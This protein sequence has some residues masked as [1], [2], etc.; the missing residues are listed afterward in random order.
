VRP[1]GRLSTCTFYATFNAYLPP[2]Y[3]LGLYG[4]GHRPTT[5][6]IITS[7]S[8]TNRQIH[9]CLDSV[10]LIA[11]NPW[12]K[13]TMSEAVPNNQSSDLLS[14]RI[15]NESSSNNDEVEPGSSL[16]DYSSPTRK[17]RIVR[18]RRNSMGVEI[19]RSYT[20][21]APEVTKNGD[22]IKSSQIERIP[23]SP[24][25]PS[26][27]Q[28]R[29]SSLGASMGS[30]Y[31]YNNDINLD[32]KI[33]TLISPSKKKIVRVR[34]NSLGVEIERTYA[35]GTTNDDFS[36]SAG[37]NCS[38]NVQ[39]PSSPS[40][41]RFVRIHRNSSGVE[42]GRSYV[43]APKAKQDITVMNSTSSIGSKTNDTIPSVQLSPTAALGQSKS[44]MFSPGKISSPSKVASQRMKSISRNVHMKAMEQSSSDINTLDLLLPPIDAG[45]GN[46]SNV[47]EALLQKKSIR[48]TTT[49]NKHD[50]VPP[51]SPA[52]A[53]KVKSLKANLSTKTAE[54]GSPGNHFITSPSLRSRSMRMYP[55]TDNAS[56]TDDHQAQSLRLLRVLLGE[57]NAVMS[58]ENV[59]KALEK[60][61]ELLRFQLQQKKKIKQ[62]DEMIQQE[63]KQQ[64]EMMEEHKRQIVKLNED[65]QKQKLL[66][67]TSLEIKDVE[68]GILTKESEQ[69]TV[70]VQQLA[71][72]L[73]K[74]RAAAKES[75]SHDSA[76]SVVSSEGQLSDN[77]EDSNSL[78]D[79]LN[80]IEQP[81]ELDD[82]DISEATPLVGHTSFSS[83]PSPNKSR[84]SSSNGEG[85]ES[86]PQMKTSQLKKKLDQT[87]RQLLIAKKSILQLE[88]KQQEM[89]LDFEETLHESKA[90]VTQLKAVLTACNERRRVAEQMLRDLGK[91]DEA[92]LIKISRKPPNELM[93]DISERGIA[94]KVGA[95]TMSE[96]ENSSSAR[97]E[98]VILEKEVENLRAQLNDAKSRSFKLEVDN[99]MS[100]K[101]VQATKEEKAKLES[102]LTSLQMKLKDCE[103]QLAAAKTKNAEKLKATATSLRE[104]E[105]VTTEC[106]V[107]N[108]MN[109]V[110]MESQIKHLQLELDES[111][112]MYAKLQT[113]LSLKV[114][115]SVRA[116]AASEERSAKLEA[117]M[118]QAVNNKEKV[119]R[120]MEQ[121]QLELDEARLLLHQSESMIKKYASRLQEANATVKECEETIAK[122]NEQIEFKNNE[123]ANGSV[124]PSGEVTADSV[125]EIHAML[126]ETQVQVKE[127]E[128]K[129]EQVQLA[130]QESETMA[131]KYLL[132]L[133]EANA[134][135]EQSEKLMRQYDRMQPNLLLHG[136]SSID[137]SEIASG[138]SESEGTDDLSMKSTQDLLAYASKRLNG[139][140]PN[141]QICDDTSNVVDDDASNSQSNVFQ[142]KG[143][144]QNKARGT[145]HFKSSAGERQECS[146]V[147]SVT[148]TN[149]GEI[150]H[151]GNSL[152]HKW[153]KSRLQNASISKIAALETELAERQIQLNE[154]L[155]KIADLTRSKDAA[156][157]QS[158]A[159][160][161]RNGD[162]S[163]DSE[164]AVALAE[165]TELKERVAIAEDKYNEATKKLIFL[166]ETVLT[167]VDTKMSILK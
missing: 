115:E 27:L 135:L 104:I 15:N 62:R 141:A 46:N 10:T 102:Q 122:L 129:L 75:R 3:S 159:A 45:S 84:K 5:S 81:K 125:A 7:K 65:V 38:D 138:D 127:Y 90:K 86:S 58:K 17:T 117:E 97:K 118:L 93:S 48:S 137:N 2:V 53:R 130:L 79:L 71:W 126:I 91:F 67:K 99:E 89:E 33:S 69:K 42:I 154:A 134:T 50:S 152:L 66:M 124:S 21:A 57:D 95:L 153:E 34:R 131:E 9:Y 82:D 133:E 88:K 70:K 161:V 144:E 64:E 98:H 32:S 109:K 56:N 128:T 16:I 22:D 103:V 72:R 8:A 14:P 140:P 11:S 41:T 36:N 77:K 146:D 156:T 59:D 44:S 28:H 111:R 132:M 52:T 63:K 80:I 25:K 23:L 143:T 101:E 149:V 30:A 106:S 120:D 150:D 31:D 145:F 100:V 12:I 4:I 155:H 74:E 68:I 116:M 108:E 20:D 107:A 83:F 151:T 136:G 43:D 119:E 78:L 166:K 94:M 148:S 158:G 60:H 54:G 157:V 110:K 163:P 139:I 35:D 105:K 13:K 123:H 40:K 87:E 18:V 147:S 96:S 24:L 167:V 47:D 160:N 39:L 26:L 51:I 165:V 113:E 162:M 92:T 1:F 85:D 29:R 61:A 164:L 73:A 121:H 142:K 37:S 76:I 55:G 19:G 112:E 49:S 6:S 114:E